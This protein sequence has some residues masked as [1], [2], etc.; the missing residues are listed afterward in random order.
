[1]ILCIPVNR[2]NIFR[3][4]LFINEVPSVVQAEVFLTAG[5]LAESSAIFLDGCWKYGATD[6]NHGNH[7]IITNITIAANTTGV[8]SGNTLI[9]TSS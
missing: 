5:A 7:G 3:K 4:C 1:M 6:W 8:N 9:V 2:L